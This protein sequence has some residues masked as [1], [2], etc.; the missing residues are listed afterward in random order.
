[1][2]E[3]RLEREAQSEGERF[4]GTNLRIREEGTGTGR[5]YQE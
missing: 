3:K 4:R 5:D 1:L 2:K